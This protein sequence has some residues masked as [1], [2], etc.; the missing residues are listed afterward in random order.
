MLAEA[1]G[2]SDILLRRDMTR[3]TLR[4][5]LQ[6]HT[7]PAQPGRRGYYAEMFLTQRGRQET[8]IGL[9][10]SWHVDRSTRD[11]EALYL[12]T[13]GPDDTDFYYTRLFIRE[14]YGYGPNASIDR[15]EGGNVLP[16]ASVRRHFGGRWAGL[17]D[18]TDIL[19]VPMIWVHENVCTCMVKQQS[20]LSLPL[21]HLPITYL[22]S[23]NISG[24][25]CCD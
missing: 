10:E 21:S 15:D 3:A 1:R 17:T 9:I 12:G 7:D 16:A 2:T 23:N 13:D 22:C 4:M 20:Y 25:M 14:S 18:E 5:S 8:F 6:V 19:Y 11:W 24:L